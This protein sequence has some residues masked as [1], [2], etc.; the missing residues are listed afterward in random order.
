LMS[1]AIPLPK[2]STIDRFSDI[3][4]LVSL[5]AIRAHVATG[6]AALKA[7]TS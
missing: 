4:K 5:F 7:T 2:P 3:F 1:L 6:Y